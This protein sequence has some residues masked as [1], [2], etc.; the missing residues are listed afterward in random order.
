MLRLIVLSCALLA[1]IGCGSDGGVELNEEA[2]M[3]P[4]SDEMK[5]E[6]PEQYAVTF[7]TT[8]GNFVLTVYR[9]W[10]PRGADR[11]YNLVTNGFYNEQRFF[12][13][14]PGFV[15]QWGMSGDPE[16]TKEWANAQF[17]DDPVKESNTRGRISFA[18]TNRPNSRTTQVFINLGDNTNLDGMRFAPFGEVTEGM[19]VVD[20]INA[21]YG[22]QASQGY[23]AE[24]GNA[25]LQEAFPNMDYIKSVRVD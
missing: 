5:T 10:A 15:V 22:Q 20:K 11:F 12:R 9:D 24:Q 13:V 16:I 14:V 4:T 3:E 7:E 23:I 1:A 2:L 25:Y 8:A 17:L 6:A 19:D 21:E 18:A